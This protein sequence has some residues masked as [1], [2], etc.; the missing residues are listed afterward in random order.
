MDP[1]NIIT[2]VTEGI[3]NKNSNKIL[4]SPLKIN[5]FEHQK[6][7]IQSMIEIENDEYQ[8]SNYHDFG[9][10]TD[11][12]G[13]GKSIIILAL[14]SINKT[15]ELNKKQK[16]RYEV[17]NNPY[18]NRNGKC[19]NEI[20]PSYYDKENCIFIKSNLI[21]VPH[22]LHKQ[23]EEYITNYTN[24]TYY[25]IKRDKDIFDNYE[26][27]NKYDIILCKNNCY[28]TFA[29]L[30]SRLKYNTSDIE[31]NPQM[32]HFLKNYNFPKM[33]SD[34]KNITEEFF[35]TFNKKLLEFNIY[36][37]SYD[38]SEKSMNTFLEKTDSLRENFEKIEKIAKQVRLTKAKYL[39][40]YKKKNMNEYT[41]K[42]MN[43]SGIVWERIIFD[44]SDS[45]NITNCEMMYS[46]FIWFVSSSYQNL[47]FPNRI[48]YFLYNHFNSNTLNKLFPN[49]RGIPHIGFIREIL[50]DNMIYEN[51]EFLNR[52]FIKTEKEFLNDSIKGVLPEP[53]IRKI[54]CKTPLELL[55]LDNV[56]S[57]DALKLLNANCH[58]QAFELLGFDTQTEDDLISNI[59]KD[60]DQQ[61]NKINTRIQE[62]EQRIQN[63]K[64]KINKFISR[65]QEIEKSLDPKN[66]IIS[67]FER[68]LLEKEIKDI[69]YNSYKY[70]EQL[71]LT[72]EHIE[73]DNMNKNSIQNQYNSLN[74]KIVLMNENICPITKEPMQNPVLIKCCNNFIDLSSLIQLIQYEFTEC[75][76]CRSDLETKN[77]TILSN[78]KVSVNSDEKKELREKVDEL[79]ILLEKKDGKFLIFSEFDNTFRMVIKK[80]EQ[81]NIPYRTLKGSE[82]TIQTTLEEFKNGTVKVLL[83]NAKYYGSGLNITECTDIVFMHRMD[84]GLEHQVIGR[85]QRI[86]RKDPL[87]INYLCYNN[88]LY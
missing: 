82:G 88:E 8:Y 41:Q 86:G 32:T 20:I 57:D 67:N 68:E 17:R 28:N 48:P 64:I 63:Y 2:N 56:I 3:I 10:I 31:R 79:M 65:Y 80:L 16:I 72:Q 13:T 54:L 44:E 18:Y 50:S 76:L 9:L 21:V 60:F 53:I 55:L 22:S 23:W 11:N 34:V 37:N 77:L 46:K 42:I 4:N 6:A 87:N 74:D 75:P 81:S 38:E 69:D 62:N 43:K 25:S 15:I 66:D 27:Y 51:Y 59:K 47:L 12:A 26:D 1:K 30:L 45:I 40:D 24:L 36:T 29:K 33:S 52:I 70:R 61:I 73:K 14:I 84:Q 83:L 58:K 39:E 35:H 71:K 85:G 7:V 49:V 19:I 78:I 5:L